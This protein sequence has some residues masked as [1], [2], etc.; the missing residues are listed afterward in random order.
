[1]VCW[2]ESEYGDCASVGS[3]VQRVARASAWYSCSNQEASERRSAHLGIS[4]FSQNCADCVSSVRHEMGGS[5]LRGSLLVTAKCYCDQILHTPPHSPPPWRCSHC[6]SDAA[7]CL[8]SSGSTCS[9]WWCPES[10]ARPCCCLF[11][12]AQALCGGS[13]CVLAV[14]VLYLQLCRRSAW[15]VLTDLCVPLTNGSAVLGCR[16]SWTV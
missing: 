9:L 5:T 12:W 3:H 8:G 15:Y 1:M 10:A 16:L 11:V 13:L 7:T 14:H 6:I 4:V 2:E